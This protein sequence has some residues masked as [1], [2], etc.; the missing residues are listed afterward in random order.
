MG[1]YSM[2]ENRETV[3]MVATDLFLR[4]LR[5][6]CFDLFLDTLLEIDIE[7]SNEWK[8]KLIAPKLRNT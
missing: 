2:L 3:L 6:S 8:A 4:V 7:L 5:H 1:K